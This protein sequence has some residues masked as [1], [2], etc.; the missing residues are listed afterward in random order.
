MRHSPATGVPDGKK[1]S[2]RLSFAPA[3]AQVREH[4][5]SQDDRLLAVWSEHAFVIFDVPGNRELFTNETENH[6]FIDNAEFSPDGRWFAVASHLREET[7]PT[8]LRLFSVERKV[9][10]R[11]LST[12]S[13]WS[14]QIG[15]DSRTWAWLEP[16]MA[17]AAGMRLHVDPLVDGAAARQFDLANANNQQ[18]WRLEWSRSGRV[19]V[20]SGGDDLWVID[21]DAGRVHR[22]DSWSD[23]VL[24]R[25]GDG[26]AWADKGGFYLW[27]PQRDLPLKLSDARCTPPSTQELPGSRFVFSDDERTLASSGA[28]SVCLWD[29]NSGSLKAILRQPGPQAPSP[30]AWFNSDRGL[31]VDSVLWDV[32]HERRVG[33]GFAEVRAQGSQVVALQVPDEPEQFVR[34]QSFDAQFAVH[35]AVTVLRKDCSLDLTG[36]PPLLVTVGDGVVITCGKQPM[37]VNLNTN[38]TSRRSI[39]GDA[40]L[41]AS[42]TGRYMTIVTKERIAIAEPSK[43]TP[44][45]QVLQH[46][47]MA[48]SGFDDG[49]LWMVNSPEWQKFDWASLE[50]SKKRPPQLARGTV[51]QPCGKRDRYNVGSHFIWSSLTEEGKGVVLCDASSGRQ[52]GALDIEGTNY[53]S[54]VNADGSLAVVTSKR[55]GVSRFWFVAEQ[56]TTEMG[57]RLY[58][59]QFSGPHTIVGNGESGIVSLDALTGVQSGGWTA[60]KKEL[61]LAADAESQRLL[62]SG[63]G[64]TLYNLETGTVIARWP[65]RD[66]RS[67]AFGPKALLVAADEQRIW[68]WQLPA[69]EPAGELLVDTAGVVFLHANG[70]FETT[71]PTTNLGALL[72]C[73]SGLKRLPLHRCTRVLGEPGLLAQVFAQVVK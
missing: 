67:A 72:T 24:A 23:P 73:G 33:G 53:V 16:G 46:E 71:L 41:T 2:L 57:S 61:I 28:A 8:T 5:W 69:T 51:T 6:A 38:T 17:E 59:V 68:V 15:R 29:T 27:S 44:E 49:R 45:Q 25:H 48:V 54:A 52:L 11:T 43:V 40:K 21:G 55:T 39:P 64:A 70:K 7:G 65:T 66:L 22:Y 3:V 47:A 20:L 56:R 10:A 37:F 32:E 36:G 4:R 14:W 31:L 35:D 19:F 34:L 18:F 42:S 9:V 1:G 26:V 12:V 13:A 50:F 58:E 62:V 63:K 30:V 60:E